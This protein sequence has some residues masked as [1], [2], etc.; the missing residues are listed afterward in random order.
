DATP[1][2]VPSPWNVNTWGT[3]RDVGPGTARPCTADSV[4]FPSYP[5]SWDGVEM[6]WLRRTFRVPADW[7][8]R[9]I[10]LHFEGVAGEAQVLVNGQR[11]GSHFDTF[12]PFDLNVT[13]LVKPGDNELLVGIRKSHLF[14]KISP[15]YPPN[16]RRTYP[17]GSNMDDLAGIW[18]DVFL[19]GLPAVRV[20]DVFIKPLVDQSTLEAEITL[21]NDT[22]QAQTVSIGGD[23]QPWVNLAGTDVLSAPEP[24]WRL[25]PAV[26]RLT[27]QSVTIA[28]GATANVTLRQK[29]DNQLRFWTPTTPN[30]YG[31]VLKVTQGRAVLDSQY[32]RFGWRQFKIQGRDLLLNG[33]KIQLAGDLLH[34]F[35]PFIGSRRYAW[36]FYKMIKDFGGN[37]VRPHA[38]PRPRHYLELADEMG[39]CVL[40]EA[41]IFGS[42]INLNLK[43]PVTWQRLEQHVDDLVRRDR[44]H[45]SVFG[46]SPG[47]EM[48]ALFFKTSQADRDAQY[49]LLQRLCLRPRRLDPTRDWISCDGDEDLSGVLP[50]WSKHMGIGVP[51]DLPDLDKPLMIGEHGGTYYAAPPR[52]AA[53]KGERAYES[54]EGRNE[55]LA[56]DLYR[57]IATVARPRL[58]YFSPSELAWFGI[59]HL[60]LGYRTDQRPPNREDGIFF[61][62]FVEGKPGIQVE[63]IPPYCM[64]FNPGFDPALPLYKPLP[65]F[66]AMKAA[67]GTQPSQWAALPELSKRKR[68]H[69]PATNAVAR[70]AFLGDRAGPLFQSLYLMGVPLADENETSALL[71]V[72]GER[73]SAA[74]AVKAEALASAVLGRGGRVWIMVRDKG[75]ALPQLKGVLPQDVEVTMRRAS[76]LVRGSDDPAINGFDLGQLYFV[77]ES[78]DKYIQKCGLGGPLAQSGRVLLAASNTD[79]ALFDKHGEVE[80]CSNVL[81]YEHL[82]KPAGAALVEVPRG[83]GKLRVSALDYQPQTPAF[84][85]FWRQLF[86]N[87]GVKLDKPPVTTIVASGKDGEGAL[88]RY[89]TETPSPDW[90]QPD[91]N[92]AAWKT[93]RGGFGGSV[94]N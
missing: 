7:G 47:N 91:F 49:K 28:P 43:E 27:P 23:V 79:W 86:Q 60:P 93:G 63:R 67:L 82:A 29:V 59:E 18:N 34:P 61:G 22:A 64:T 45:P 50:V 76:S 13:N 26:L 12:L 77:D 66:E 19:L 68:S 94:P 75:A 58:A 65:M 4:Y 11:A 30:L 46:W 8:N 5:P 1:L 62:P 3:G 87:V 39:L 53:I 32:T 85:T 57:M 36:A 15:D 69:P 42:S 9:R 38:Q 31:L 52:L 44:N 73:L 21:R 17:N 48:F 37:A 54:Y 71:V 92:D 16:Q 10:V 56:I 40:D 35:G 90:F 6:G 74:D 80:K 55:A 24:K 41:A 51:K 89:T 14:N 70:V 83:T 2:K 33:A 88:W 25:D 84:R 78:G 72:D 20:E 81:I